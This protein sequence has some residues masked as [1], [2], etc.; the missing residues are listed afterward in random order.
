[1]KK[2]VVIL[3]LLMATSAI[4]QVG[5]NEENPSAMLDIKSKGNS[6]STKALKVSNS[7]GTEML[8][9]LDNGNVGINVPVPTAKLHTNGSVRYENLPVISANI[10]PLAVKSDGTL[11]TYVP[12]PTKYLY[13]QMTSSVTTPGFSLSDTGVYTNIPL[14][15]AESVTNTIAAGFG[16]D[17][18]ATLDA[19][20]TS[21]SNSNVRYISFPEPGV[22]KINL[23]YYTSCSGVPTDNL[24]NML[25]IGTA[26]FKANPG[27]TTYVR[28]AVV[29]YNG[30]PKRTDTGT[31]AAGPY[32][33]A[34]PHTV[35]L[36][37]ETKAANEKIALFVNYGFG[38]TYPANVCSFAV[39]VG[40]PNKI[41]MNISK[42]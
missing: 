14:S 22:Y 31:V 19:G 18:T 8:T 7:N 12:E 32:S 6:A 5:I 15:A 20:G 21:I 33:Y 30:L 39:P 37:F 3:C 2:N 4:A 11:G 10:S 13:M 28:Q 35:Y 42:L 1:M 16:T 17:V 27:T 34:V 26:L 9:V 29:R 38:D 25:G 40:V 36:V 24:N 41:M 23:N